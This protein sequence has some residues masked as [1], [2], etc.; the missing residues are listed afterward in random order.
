M[1]P[2]RKSCGSFFFYF[3]RHVPWLILIQDRRSKT[4]RSSIS[5]LVCFIDTFSFW[6]VPFVTKYTPASP[7]PL[8]FWRFTYP[9]HL[10]IYLFCVTVST[11]RHAVRAIAN[12]LEDDWQKNSLRATSIT[13]AAFGMVVFAILVGMVTETVESIVRNADGENTRVL[14]S[15]HIV[16]CDWGPHVAQIIKDVNDVTSDV[17]V[18]VLAAPDKKQ[19]LMDDIRSLLP[20]DAQKNMRIYYRPGAPTVPQDLLRVNASQARKIILVSGREGDPVDRDRIILSRALALRQNLPAFRGDIVAELSSTRDESLVQAILG[21]SKARTVE[22]INTEQLL[23]RF[24]AQAIRQPGLADIVSLLMGDNQMSV[25]HITSAKEAAPQLVGTNFSDMRPTSV[26][27]AILCGFVDSNGVHM[28]TAP[29]YG[30]LETIKPDTEMLLLGATKAMRSIVMPANQGPL[31]LSPSM[32]GMMQRFIQN[33]SRAKRGHPERF[34]V[35][36]WRKDMESMLQELDNVLPRGSSV[37]I[38]DQ[39]VPDKLYL[40]LRHLKVELVKKRADRYE[41]IESLVTGRSRPYDHVVVIGAS[42]GRDSDNGMETSRNDDARTL[43]TLVYVNDVLAKQRTERNMSRDKQ[44]LVTVEFLR[45][46]VARMIKEQSDIANAILPQN[47]GSKITAQTVRDSRLNAVWRE[48]L[49]QEGREVY[50]RPVSAYKGFAKTRSSFATL[51]DQ[52][53]KS[54]DDILIGFIPSYIPKVKINPQGPERFTAREWN[55]NDI[56]IVLSN[57]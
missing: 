33:H 26:P 54:S 30:G 50:L 16:V 31:E 18:V 37:R 23:F 46:D 9:V 43:A 38:V 42:V 7:S 28:Q 20:D 17:K 52:L 47:L 1:A 44:P 57:E 5:I 53:A 34:L 29:K 55:E 10:F 39:D 51:A 40:S 13:L 19:A 32:A 14:V 4:R 11:C 48:L 3:A 21:R 41:N 6:T 24:M 27:G 15:D 25:F 45:E 56:L 2:E 22:T 8:F 36:G 35:L 12:P 49:S